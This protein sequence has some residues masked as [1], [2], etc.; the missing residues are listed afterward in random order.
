MA[1][2]EDV[3][4]W[5]ESSATAWVRDALR[6]I[7]TQA[8]LSDADVE[9]L[10]ELCK[11][12]HG[13]SETANAPQPLTV[14]HL[15]RSNE[16]GAVSVVA[17]THVADVNALA[18][19]ET[20][21]FAKAGLTVVYGDNGAGKSGYARIL[22]R[23]CRARGSSEPVL[24]NALSEQPA[25]SPTAQIRIDVGG[26]ER[27]H[28][29][30]DGTASAVEL[31]AVS[32]FDAS[33]AQVYVADRTEV[34][35]RPFGLDVLD[36]LASVCTKVKARLD[37]ERTALESRTATWPRIPDDTEV[38]RLL[39]GL[40]ALTRVDEVKRLAS[41]TST[42]DEERVMLEAVLAAAK[43]EDPSKRAADLK[44]KAAR[45][46]RL[47]EELRTTAVQLDESAVNELTR[48]RAAA[49]DAEA[50]ASVLARSFGDAARLPGLG[51]RAW[52][53]L[54]EA[55]QAYSRSTPYP[56][57]D[58]PVVSEDALCVL[59]HQKLSGEARARFE[60][61]AAFVRG[62]A[63]QAAQKATATLKERERQLS[64]LS[65]G[66]SH[67]DARDDLATIDAG[68]SG[69]VEA[70]FRA[71][72]GRRNALLQ[73]P[74]GAAVALPEA[75]VAGLQ[76]V[77]AEFETRAKELARTADPAERRTSER[78]HS[79]LRAR[80]MLADIKEMVLAEIHRKARINAYTNCAKDTDTRGLTRLSTELTKKYVT[81]VLTAAFDDELKRLGFTAP[82]IELRP[83]GGQRGNLYHQVQL[84][85]VTRAELPKVVSEGEGRCIAL[86][87]FFAE[88]RSA[89]H[90]SGIVFDDPVSSLDHRWRTRVAE[91]LVELGKDRQVIVFTHELVFLHALMHAA[92]KG[93]LPCSAQSVWRKPSTC[94][95]VDSDLPWA[96]LSTQRRLGWIK[97]EWQRAEKCFRVDG[98]RVYGPIAT[99]L[100]ARL[101]QT[102]ERA[103]EEV[104]LCGVVERF[105][106]SVETQRLRRLQD[107][108]QSDLAAVAAGMTKCSK[109]EGGH[110]HAL[111]ANEPVPSPKEL[112]D[113]IAS[114]ETWV[115]AVE[116]RRRRTP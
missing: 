107:I 38:A 98:E 96:A 106:A 34:R 26:V 64:G 21:A 87:A 67:R 104:L 116:E 43:L 31:G 55:A 77:V 8:E 102:W 1:V 99:H 72:E 19:G 100:Y 112:R 68:L 14:G 22:K 41:L 93:G 37:Q 90:P 12:P 52:R 75:P 44:S 109:W 103:V 89:G 110:D 86:A 61:F 50:A 25:G 29:W 79:E 28:T 20:I 108:D 56:D 114:L 80:H 46:A 97:N 7:V 49:V 40:T 92:E 3:Y 45:I 15:P 105:R 65:I 30:K 60:K 23:A 101:R 17:I 59:C 24:P 6:R 84:R 47:A 42:E 74:P 83:V 18:P 63:Q 54:W 94:G 4:A 81:E 51:D 35:F 78:R 82:E 95:H 91:R 53:Q 57:R 9:A 58:F 69:L 33:A 76:R 27:S 62:D 88:L 113:D 39:N 5:S 10:T 48:L 85:H 13:L 2:L 70:F 66:A 11:K 111:A 32:V 71:A 115:R 73:T 36:R 16:T